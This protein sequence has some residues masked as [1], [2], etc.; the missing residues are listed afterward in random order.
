[1]KL[2]TPAG[3]Q[4]YGGATLTT[5]KDRDGNIYL[6]GNATDRS[7]ASDDPERFRFVVFRYARQGGAITRLHLEDDQDHIA[8]R[9][10]LYIDPGDGRGYYSASQNNIA[11]WGAIPGFVPVPVGTQVVAQPGDVATQAVLDRLE[12]LERRL[13]ELEARPGADAALAKAQEAANLANSAYSKAK[14]AIDDVWSKAMSRVEGVERQV[15][16][17][18]D[19]ATA[20]SIAWEKGKQATFYEVATEGSGTHLAIEDL[21]RRMVNAGTGSGSAV[22]EQ[23]RK[24]ADA[25]LREAQEAL[26]E[27]QR[28]PTLDDVSR[29]F[30]EWM[31]SQWQEW[32]TYTDR[33]LLN[34]IWDRSVK[35]LRYKESN[36]KTAEELPINDPDNLK[37]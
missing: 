24:G 6:G 4:Y 34:L 13:A 16:G 18:I 5:I 25:A 26:A 15:A 11:Y 19:G 12:R 22:D 32:V 21:I 33:R 29:S 8:G 9:G 35:L 27:A 1:M 31:D 10:I 20:E 2:T 14:Q 3:Y 23:A 28:R 17:K 37:V 7:K 30:R 36:N